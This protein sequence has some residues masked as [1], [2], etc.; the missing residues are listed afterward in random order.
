MTISLNESTREDFQ[1]QVYQIRNLI[2]CAP[3]FRHFFNCDSL[4]MYE[5]I[6]FLWLFA[7][8]GIW[9][10]LCV[11]VLYFVHVAFNIRCS[12]FRLLRTSS[13]VHSVFPKSLYLFICQICHILYFVTLKISYARKCTLY[14]QFVQFVHGM[15]GEP[16]TC[17]H[18]CPL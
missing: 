9:P 6:R 4:H 15:Q 12:D 18:I 10:F 11:F 13:L 5:T 3:N 16:K 14:V 7:M 17:V 8:L 1:N 2:K